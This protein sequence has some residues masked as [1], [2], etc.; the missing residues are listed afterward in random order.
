MATSMFLTIVACRPHDTVNRILN[1]NTHCCKLTFVHIGMS[2]N[3]IKSTTKRT[4]IK[5]VSLSQTFTSH[6][7]FINN[8]SM[9]TP[10][11]TLFCLIYSLFYLVNLLIVYMFNTYAKMITMTN[12]FKSMRALKYSRWIIIP[13]KMV[14]S[15]QIESPVWVPREDNFIL[16]LIFKWQHV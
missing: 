4:L 6:I 13:Q 5:Y 14:T 10:L 2:N 12:D 3:S 1:Y 11:F 9:N 16:Q 15:M 8:L 7:N